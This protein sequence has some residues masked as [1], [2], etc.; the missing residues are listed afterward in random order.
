MFTV[1]TTKA[2]AW[3]TAVFAVLMS[4]SAVFADNVVGVGEVGTFVTLLIESVAA[5]ATVYK[6]PNK[7]IS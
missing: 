2:K 3:V 7:R 5:V 1:R 6:V 4:L